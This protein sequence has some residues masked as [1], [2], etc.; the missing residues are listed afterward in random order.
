MNY[1]AFIIID[2]EAG[3]LY[4]DFF[5]EPMDYTNP[6]EQISKKYTFCAA[7]PALHNKLQEIIQR[8]S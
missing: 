6:L 7:S 5:G 3:G 8:H 2:E 1:Q 4:T